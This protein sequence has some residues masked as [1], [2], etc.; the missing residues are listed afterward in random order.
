MSVSVPTAWTR[1]WAHSGYGLAGGERRV[2]AQG[3]A[4]DGHDQLQ[5]LLSLAD[6][7]LAP[8]HITLP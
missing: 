8:Y 3:G 7:P 4:W 6:M 2:I 5:L 1:A